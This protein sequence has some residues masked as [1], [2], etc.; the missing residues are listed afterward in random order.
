MLIGNFSFVPARTVETAVAKL[1]RRRDIQ[2]Q[3][4]RVRPARTQARPSR[5][6]AFGPSS[7][8]VRG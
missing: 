6:Q 2:R 3:V 1:G 4:G 5:S 8:A 7:T